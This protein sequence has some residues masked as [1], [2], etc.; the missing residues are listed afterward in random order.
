MPFDD[1]E[2]VVHPQ[3]V[4]HSMVQFPGRFHH[5]PKASPPDMRLPIALGLVWPDAASVAQ[6]CDWTH[7]ARW[8][9][10]PLDRCVSRRLGWRWRLD[11]PG[12]GSG[13]VQR[14]Q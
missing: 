13:R 6:A 7:I 5:R 14:R 10:R 11:V 3:S 4:V 1:I 2:V 8:D 12:D 9:F